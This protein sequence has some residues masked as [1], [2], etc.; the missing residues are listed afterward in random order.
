MIIDKTNLLSE[1]QAVTATAASANII[2]LGVS[3]DIGRGTPV[4]LLVQ[5]TEAFDELTSLTVTVQTDDAEGF[6][7]AKDLTSQTMLLADLVKG[8]QFDFLILPTGI[9]RYLRLNYTV[10]GDTPTTGKITAGVTM[11]NSGVL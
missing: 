10:V 11:G 5:V 3:R 8:K 9:K 4:P 2:D 1:N 7:T 6:G